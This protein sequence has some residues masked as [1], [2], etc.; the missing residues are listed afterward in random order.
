[1]AKLAWLGLGAMGARMAARLIAA[2]HDLTVWNRTAEKTTPLV[3]AGAV[4]ADS[5]PAAVAGADMVFAML[6]DDD[7]ARAVWLDPSSGALPAMAPGSLAID[8]STLSVPGA[9]A[10]AAAFAKSD[11]RFVEAPVS[12]S[13]PQA[14]GG[15]LIFLAGGAAD[16]I[17]AARPLLVDLG[18]AVHH[19]GDHGAGATVKLMINALFGAQVAALAELIAFARKCGVDPERA[20]DIAGQTPIMSPIAKFSAGGMLSRAFAPAFPIDLVVKDFGLVATSAEAAGA[21]AP[22]AKATGEIF[23]A[24]AD[25]GYAGDNITGVAQVYD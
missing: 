18:A 6:R 9:R 11:V 14:E 23:E 5:P 13:L 4:A 1:M 8:F 24:A 7:A 17:D 10:L 12:G 19:A 2:G 16:D 3:A 15:Q 21:K 20:I 25:R 22:L